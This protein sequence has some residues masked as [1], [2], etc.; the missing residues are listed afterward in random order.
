M[1]YFTFICIKDLLLHKK[2]GIRTPAPIFRAL[3]REVRFRQL[4]LSEKLYF[5]PNPLSRIFSAAARR[6]R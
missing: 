3:I 4:L 6:P 5:I 1:T 2:T